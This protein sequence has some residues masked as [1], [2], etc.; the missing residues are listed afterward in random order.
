MYPAKN[1]P[2]NNK[3]VVEQSGTSESERKK[4][5]EQDASYKADWSYLSPRESDLGH[6]TA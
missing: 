5:G 4:Y 1:S 3:G 6:V 2:K